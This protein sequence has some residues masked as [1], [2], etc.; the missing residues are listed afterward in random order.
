MT[1]TIVAAFIWCWTP[2]VVMT[3]WYMFDRESAKKV[4][5]RLQDALFIMAVSNSCVNPL[6]YGSYAMRSCPLLHRRRDRE[7]AAVAQPLLMATRPPPRRRHVGALPPTA[8]SW[9][10]TADAASRTSSSASSSH[11]RPATR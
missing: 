4:D 7:R 10:A 8:I 11:H 9:R 2:Y 5:Q 6:V 1:I 3:L